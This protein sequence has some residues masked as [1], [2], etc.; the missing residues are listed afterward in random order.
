M[1]ASE[2]ATCLMR[3]SSFAW[4]R[5]GVDIT[6]VNQVCVRNGVTAT[7]Y[8]FAC[9]TLIVCSNFRG[10]L[11]LRFDEQRI[12]PVQSIFD[13]PVTQSATAVKLNLLIAYGPW[14]V[15]FFLGGDRSHT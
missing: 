1:V 3:S 8:Q 5:T 11:S 4:F 9:G 15:Q 13:Q 10:R 2:S 14:K 12:T 7:F 6:A